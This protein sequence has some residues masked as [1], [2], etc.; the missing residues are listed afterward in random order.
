M[1]LNYSRMSLGTLIVL[2][3]RLDVCV[4]QVQRQVLAVALRTSLANCGIGGK[5]PLAI[6]GEFD[7]QTSGTRIC[8]Y[9][10][11]SDLH[12]GLLVDTRALQHETKVTLAVVCRSLRA[13]ASGYGRG[14][15]WSAEAGLAL[16]GF[17]HCTTTLLFSGPGH[18]NQRIRRSKPCEV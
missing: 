7:Q 15:A 17:V 5:R 10:S 1:E 2:Q 16:A 12:L 6:E 13:V 14:A 9:G 8:Q 11:R 3:R 18:A 4:G